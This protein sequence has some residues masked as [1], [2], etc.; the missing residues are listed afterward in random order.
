MQPSFTTGSLPKQQ[1]FDRSGSDA[2]GRSRVG[3]RR[4]GCCCSIARCIVRR[5][6]FFD[7]VGS[8]THETAAVTLIR[9]ELIGQCSCN[10]GGSARVD[11]L[12]VEH[13]R[14]RQIFFVSILF[15]DFGCNLQG[16]T[17][18]AGAGQS[19]MARY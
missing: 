2:R 7:C 4:K 6:T 16:G 15:E 8:G 19:K 13:L 10:V 1:F 18:E 5:N 3:Q 17:Y 14:E 12:Q 9:Q 11:V